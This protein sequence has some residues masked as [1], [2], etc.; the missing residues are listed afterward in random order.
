MNNVTVSYKW[1][2]ELFKGK[3]TWNF[4][5]L[6]VWCFLY[7][8]RFSKKTVAKLFTAGWTFHRRSISRQKE[9]EKER[10]HWHLS[11]CTTPGQT[12][13]QDIHTHTFTLLGFKPWRWNVLTGSCCLI[14]DLSSQYLST[15]RLC[16]FWSFPSIQ[17][18]VC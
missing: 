9:S 4:L 12:W 16:V 14:T 15:V 13:R 8:P 2:I 10:T 6:I 5:T 3:L 7:L 17:F 11:E 18:T 1:V